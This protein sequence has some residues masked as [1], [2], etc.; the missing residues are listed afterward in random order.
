MSFDNY[1]SFHPSIEGPVSFQRSPSADFFGGSPLINL[2]NMMG[3]KTP[4]P[5]KFDIAAWNGPKMERDD[6]PMGPV[7]VDFESVVPNDGQFIL[8]ALPLIVPPGQAHQF[9][10]TSM[11]HS[12]MPLMPQVAQ[13]IA[14][15]P[16]AVKEHKSDLQLQALVV[17]PAQSPQHQNHQQAVAMEVDSTKAETKTKVAVMKP[18]PKPK[19]TPVMQQASNSSTKRRRAP[20][21]RLSR[22]LAEK[23]RAVLQIHS[24][25]MDLTQPLS[26]IAGLPVTLK[27]DE[28]TGE[29]FVGK[30]T[31]SQRKLRL[32]RFKQKFAHLPPYKAYSRKNKPRYA[33]R[34]RFAKGRNRVGGRFVSNPKAEDEE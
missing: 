15:E 5:Y 6:D 7:K 23:L 25:Q 13:P 22:Q 14:P 8:G 33:S 4:N 1:P 28:E 12:A 18:K 9:A 11:T 16:V 32:Q 31:V 3:L 24:E 34:S 21:G 2:D 10:E 27:K 17:P 29:H 26:T 30:Y 19:S 20:A